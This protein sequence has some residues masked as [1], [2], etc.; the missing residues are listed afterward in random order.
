V[1]RASAIEQFGLSRLWRTWPAVFCAT[2]AAAT[3]AFLLLPWSLEGKSLAVLHGLC[4]QQPHHS[5]YF[6]EQ[7][8]PFDARMTGI[9]GGFAVA[10]VYLLARGRWRAG[11]LPS[12]AMLLTLALFV[13]ALGLDG[14]NSTLRD[15]GQPYLYEPR[16][17]VRLITGLLTGTA[18]AA[19]IWL[20]LAQVG[21]AR[22]ARRAGAPITGARDVGLLLTAQAAFAALA[23][24]G[25]SALRVP[26]TFVLLVAAIGAVTGLALGFVLLL[27]RRECRAL[28]TSDLAGPAAVAL[29]TALVVIGS[30]S[31][32]RFLLEA[33]LDIPP[34]VAEARR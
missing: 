27:G 28:R 13:A 1:D 25:W 19:F 34:A 5:L 14:V 29:V 32:G 20:L 3:I 26:V 6:G 30:L 10:S 22:R 12:V 4:A 33:W 17:P 15:L 16:N 31:G 11:G 8:L 24:S 7:R 18:L 23:L 2:L 21:F 9:Y